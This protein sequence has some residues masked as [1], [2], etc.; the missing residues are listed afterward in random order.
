MN[1]PLVLEQSENVYTW[2]GAIGLKGVPRGV[3]TF[4]QKKTFFCLKSISFVLRYQKMFSNSFLVLGLVFPE[5]FESLVGMD[6]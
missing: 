3:D 2:A 6:F 1:A 4:R 5:L